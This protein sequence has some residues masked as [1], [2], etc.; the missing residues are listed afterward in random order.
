MTEL[1]IL[2]IHGAGATP[3][4]WRLQLIRFKEARA[5]ALPGHTVG[6]GYSTIGEYA[7]FL[8][9]HI[10]TNRLK[11]IILVGHSM[12]GAIA[13]EYVLSNAAPLGIVLVD[14]GARLGV[15]GEIL[16][17]IRGNYEDACRMIAQLS[18]APGCAPIVTDRL[19]RELLKVR[20]EVT[21]GDLVACDRFDRTS[22]IRKIRCPTLI[23]CGSEDQLT[24]VKHSE[25]LHREIANSELLVIPGAGHSVMLEKH[26]EFNE[27]LA[28]FEASLTRSQY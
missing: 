10:E 1:G 21:Y 19:T 12:G 24:P 2:F 16:S 18:V 22:E 13:I 15:R 26:R 3:I 11:D 4:A 7:E 5:V 20:Q 23:V 6:S 8:K 27:A 25:Y 17:K 28:A 14:T 9:R